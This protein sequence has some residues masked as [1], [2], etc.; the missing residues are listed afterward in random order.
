MHYNRQPTCWCPLPWWFQL[1]L[2]EQQPV[3]ILFPDL[4]QPR[5]RFY[6]I[7][8]HFHFLLVLSPGGQLFRI[9]F[10]WVAL[11]QLKRRG[12]CRSRHVLTSFHIK[13]CIF[14]C[15]FTNRDTME[16]TTKPV[17]PSPLGNFAGR[18]FYFRNFE[19]RCLFAEEGRRSPKA[20]FPEI[21]IGEC[22]LPLLPWTLLWQALH[23]LT[24]L[25]NSN[26]F[27][28]SSFTSTMWCTM[29]AGVKQWSSK[30]CWQR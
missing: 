3:W 9:L 18:V 28:Q 11:Y 7:G 15:F 20:S 25:S 29:S 6:I 5:W 2:I 30:Q 19:K 24:R 10:I 26:L 14:A 8:S 16:L 22:H 21:W 4:I 1:L 27:D 12:F 23:R 13:N 17:V